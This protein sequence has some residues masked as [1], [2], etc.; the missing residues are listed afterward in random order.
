[1]VETARRE[2][3]SRILFLLLVAVGL[4]AAGY[5]AFL[6][7]KVHTDPAYRSFC[8]VSAGL[9]CASVA[10]SSWAVF[11]G[12]P[13]ATWGLVGYGLIGALAFSGLR[14]RKPHG[15]W[16]NGLLFVLSG[17][18]VVAAA[19]LAV[20]SKAAIES[21]CLVCMVSWA[22]SL[23]LFG[24]AWFELRR[25]KVPA[26][27]ALRRDAVA[28]AGS[29]P[30]SVAFVGV[31]IA[32]VGALWLLYPHY[33]ETPMREGPGGLATGT[34]EDGS[35]WIGARDP[36]VTLVSFSDYECP[37]CAK[38]NFA[39]RETLEQSPG[40]RLV[41]RHYP[42]DA[43]CNPVIRGDFHKQSCRLAL[44]TTCA[45][46]QGKFWELSDAIFRTTGKV[47]A[48]LPTLIRESGV[49]GEKL[50]G[51]MES[52]RAKKKLAADVYDGMRYNIRGTPAIVYEGRLFEGGI[53]KAT[54]DRILA[55]A[56]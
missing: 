52:E 32:L 41:F 3:W 47:E 1:M 18:S 39:F 33:W 51:C 23:G 10:E 25:G 5:L 31:P 26:V 12:I 8:S 48:D 4:W 38:E 45:A 49:D 19:L 15:A 20:I 40:L 13:V 43:A 37:H 7:V 14:R 53:P 22:V 44:A 16:P 30:L 56:E 2:R 17:V 46:E 42:L 54:L 11:L 9:D 21:V 34:T 28:L 6:H 55:G 29:T 50:R 35:P 27:T 36:K 24:I